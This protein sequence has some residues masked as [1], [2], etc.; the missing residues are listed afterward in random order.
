MSTDFLLVEGFFD[1]ND[2]LTVASRFGRS[3]PRGYFSLISS[4]TIKLPGNKILIGRLTGSEPDMA[5]SDRISDALR[6]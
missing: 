2:S 5:T 6:V 1:P 3:L 4:S